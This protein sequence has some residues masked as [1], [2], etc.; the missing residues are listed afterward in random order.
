MRREPGG[1]IE[2]AMARFSGF[3][4]RIAGM[5]A[6]VALL[7]AADA[8]AGGPAQPPDGASSG[9]LVRYLIPPFAL[10]T[11]VN[12]TGQ[13]AYVW[14]WSTSHDHVAFTVQLWGDGSDPNRSPIEEHQTNGVPRTDIAEASL[15]PPDYVGAAIGR[16]LVEPLKK[17]SFECAG[18]IYDLQTQAIT[19][20]PL[21]APAAKKRK[22]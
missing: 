12:G 6:G 2:K 1:G 15:C 13:C 18:Q 17:L 16:I 3:S 22:K 20:L 10:D 5:A 7:V 11:D 4:R 9:F 21:L 19:T 8:R 14:C